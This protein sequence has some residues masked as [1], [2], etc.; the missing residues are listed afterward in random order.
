MAEA[1]I[2]VPTFSAVT[3]AAVM[4][5][6]SVIGGRL[7]PGAGMGSA[8]VNARGKASKAISRIGRTTNIGLEAMETIW[9]WQRWPDISPRKTRGARVCFHAG[10]VLN[11]ALKL[12]SKP[13]L[14][15]GYR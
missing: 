13:G 1:G 6:S 12:S 9:A 2:V 15:I 10:W 3:S 5:R 4:V 14:V 7:L 8:A 11:E